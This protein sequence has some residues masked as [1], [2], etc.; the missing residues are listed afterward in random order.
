MKKQSLVLGKINVVQPNNP[1]YAVA[2]KL[3][4]PDGRFIAIDLTVDDARAVALEMLSKI[5]ILNPT[6]FTEE[7]MLGARH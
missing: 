4:A 2:V 1:D 6:H 5:K 7:N 3:Q